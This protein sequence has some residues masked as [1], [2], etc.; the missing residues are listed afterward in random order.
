MTYENVLVPTD[1]SGGVQDSVTQALDIAERADATVHALYVVDG[2]LRKRLGDV[3]F[4]DDDLRVAGENAVA[5]IE[6]AAHRAGLD[7]K[8][9]IVEGDPAGEI[10]SYVADNA[11][12]LVVMGTHGREGAARAV[13]GSTT[14]RVLRRA[15]V[16]VL[17]VHTTKHE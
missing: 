12:D 7:A 6:G 8:T 15:D 4:R 13:L 17:V 3:A 5:S 11:I 14:E 16:P 10:L 1:G 9:E 2:S